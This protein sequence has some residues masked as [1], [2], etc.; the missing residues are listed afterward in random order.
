MAAWLSV[1]YAPAGSCLQTSPARATWRA[2]IHGATK[3][4]A[5][6]RADGGRPDAQAPVDGATSRPRTGRSPARAGG[7]RSAERRELPEPVDRTVQHPVRE[8]RHP[9]GGDRRLGCSLPA[10]CAI[11]RRPLPQECDEQR[12]S[13]SLR[14]ARA[15]SSR[16]CAGRR[17]ARPFCR[18]WTYSSL[19]LPAP[20]PGD[21]MVRARS[22]ATRQKSYRCSRAFRTGSSPGACVLLSDRNDDHRREASAARVV[23]GHERDAGQRGHDDARCGVAVTSRAARRAARDR[24]RSATAAAA[25]AAHDAA[26]DREGRGM[27]GRVRAKRVDLPR[28]G[29]RAGA[30][31]ARQERPREPARSRCAGDAAP[32]AGGA[33]TRSGT[34]TA[35]RGSPARRRLPRVSLQ[36]LRRAHGEGPRA[37]VSRRQRRR[38]RT[39]SERAPLLRLHSRSAPTAARPGTPTQRRLRP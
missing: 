17:A 36:P 35:R 8:R 15:G 18:S 14:S 28:R 1:A 31:A 7:T 11:R 39:G 3:L 32:A 24:R 4:A 26:D 9:A 27:V 6:D 30:P 33:T 21:R 19:K 38:P 37:A 5:I 10:V 22:S 23:H 16:G 29:E 20:I 34:C 13:R 25:R 12:R 2:A